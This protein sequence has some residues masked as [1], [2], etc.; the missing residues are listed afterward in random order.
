MAL[1]LVSACSSGDTGSESASG[2]TSSSS[3][4]TTTAATSES[5][6]QVVAGAVQAAN[7]FLA[8]LSDDTKKGVVFAYD[9]L[10]AKKSR[11]SNL[12]VG[13]F[14]DRQGAKLGDLD[15]SQRK[16]ALAVL[17]SMLSD[18]GME[19]VDGILAADDYLGSSTGNTDW[20]SDNYWLA[21]YGE[22]SAASPWTVQFGGHHLAMHLT[23]GG[24]TA[25]VSP[26][27]TGLEPTTFTVDGKQYSPMV[28]EADAVFGFL[29]SLSDTQ[30]SAAK[31]SG[32][33]DNVVMG[34]G[35]DTGYPSGEGGIKFSELPSELQGKARTII[36][37]WVGDADAALSDPLM[38]VY[39]SQL[40]DTTIG[41]SGSTDR[42]QKNAY[43]RID[44]PRL[45][46]EYLNVGGIGTSEI[47]Y[48]SIYRDKSIDYG[49]GAS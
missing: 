13:I 10:D 1:M 16:A 2:A 43:L 29:G 6:T 9:D 34:P 19:Q 27:F 24:G 25:S 42:T 8:T 31:L 20:N 15:D 38:E 21:F 44:G 11:W 26:L 36:K 41:W 12:P 32:T 37:L 5:N 4:A 47:H 23:V 48:H 39:E 46:L 30:L 28:G 14:K 3:P 7:A 18:Q 45:W 17:D 40:A 35:A 22:P 33:F 49:T